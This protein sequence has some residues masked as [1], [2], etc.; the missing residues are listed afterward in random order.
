MRRLLCGVGLI[1]VPIASPVM[2]FGQA[3]DRG[4]VLRRHCEDVFQLFARFVEPVHLDERAS[5]RHMRRKVCRM[6]LQAGLARRDGLF[7]LPS[8]PILFRKRRKRN[9]RRV[10]LDPASQIFDAWIFCHCGS[11]QSTTRPAGP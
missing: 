11:R 2:N 9:R 8:P 7:V 4:E 1:V 6:P 5:E 3:S 10:R